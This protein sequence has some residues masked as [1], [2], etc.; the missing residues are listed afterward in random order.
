[1]KIDTK[2]LRALQERLGYEDDPNDQGWTPKPLIANK[3]F[4]YFV[5]ERD[6]HGP[7][8]GYWMKGDV[9]DGLRKNLTVEL[10][11]VVSGNRCSR[12]KEDHYDEDG[13][14]W[15]IYC[16]I[17]VINDSIVDWLVTAMEEVERRALF[18]I[19]N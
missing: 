9:N 13:G 1:M 2:I 8:I 3:I 15:W 18:T 16:D 7:N 11:N 6:G 14:G 10:N 12:A 17:T 19:N 5:K 4:L